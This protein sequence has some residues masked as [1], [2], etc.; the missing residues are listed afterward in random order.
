MILEIESTMFIDKLWQTYTCLSSCATAHKSAQLQTQTGNLKHLC[1]DS[2]EP[3]LQSVAWRRSLLEL[4]QCRYIRCLTFATC[5]MVMI[6]ICYSFLRSAVYNDDR[7]VL[8]SEFCLMS[9]M[10]Y[11]Q[12]ILNGKGH[13]VIYS[14]VLNEKVMKCQSLQFDS[15]TMSFNSMTVNYYS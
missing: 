1:N 15:T 10:D 12:F 9:V 6:L 7:R 14:Q 5:S 3:I 4:H 13:S 11:L 8:L 2:F